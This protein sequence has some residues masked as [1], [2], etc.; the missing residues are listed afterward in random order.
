M[1]RLKRPLKKEDFISDVQPPQTAIMYYGMKP[2]SNLKEYQFFYSVY[3]KKTTP[4]DIIKKEK[5]PDRVFK[6]SSRHSLELDMQNSDF[7]TDKDFGAINKGRDND[8]RTLIGYV[9][10]PT[11]ST[12]KSSWDYACVY[13]DTDNSII[14]DWR[15]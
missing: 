1:V 11:Y 10:E 4:S 5:S 15:H 6:S 12:E 2:E 9:L 8:T 3:D 13:L 14:I 7:L